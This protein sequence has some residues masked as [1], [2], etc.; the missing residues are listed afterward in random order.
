MANQ[1]PSSPRPAGRRGRP[2]LSE[3]EQ[4]A[5]TRDLLMD[6][7][8]ALMAE[9]GSANFS[10]SEI[11]ERTGLSSA[12]VQYHFGSKEGL[13]VA[14]IARF[15]TRAIAQMR[16]LTEA[17]LP[18]AVKLRMHIGGLV[19]AAF[20]APYITRLLHTLMK[21][22]AEGISHSVA[23]MLVR[24]I[25][26]FHKTLLEQ[27]LRE[28]VF[29]PIAPMDFYFIVTGACD[30]MF[31]RQNAWREVFAIDEVTQEVKRSY[32]RSVTAIILNGIKV[33]K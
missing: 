33:T 16:E 32:A 25:Y 6:A 7:A 21:S 10:L 17:D 23:D 13:L 5:D 31:W 9:K 27:G 24:P 12:L 14:Q 11:A 15:S 28:G 26:E 3:L 1:V 19:N 8:H 22:E 30:T 2:P 4:R 18:V 29:Q 20:E